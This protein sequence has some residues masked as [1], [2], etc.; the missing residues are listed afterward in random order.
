MALT[1][2]L[3]QKRL[4]LI[5]DAINTHIDE[6]VARYQITPPSE[7]VAGDFGNDLHLL[8]IQ[9]DEL[10]TL[11]E[12]GQGTAH[13]YECW[14]DPEDNGIS[15]LRFQDVAENRAQGQLS[16]RA[17]RLYSFI[18]HTGEEAMAIHCLRQGWAP[19]VPMGEAAPCPTCQ[20]PYYPQGYG[21]CWRCGHIG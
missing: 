15:L 19:Y 10:L 6:Q 11:A 12:T 3:T 17:K 8:R 16:A 14:S 9:R 4:G 20:T 1:L 7:D 13:V 5:L 21:D 18:A 2:T